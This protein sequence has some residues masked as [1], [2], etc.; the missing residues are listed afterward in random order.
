MLFGV[1]KNYNAG[2]GYIS[3]YIGRYRYSRV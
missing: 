2:D 3:K 1:K